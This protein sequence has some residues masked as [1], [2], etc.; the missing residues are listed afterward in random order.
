MSF[1]TLWPRMPINT[2][3]LH[4]KLQSI[5]VKHLKQKICFKFV[6]LFGKGI[7]F[8]KGHAI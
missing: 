3:G 2:A 6:F 1:R 7:F 4:I 8:I 5:N